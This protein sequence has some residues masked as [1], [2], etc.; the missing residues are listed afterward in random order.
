MQYKECTNKHTHTHTHTHLVRE[1]FHILFPP[2]FW[3]T[4]ATGSLWNLKKIL[5]SFQRLGCQCRANTTVE[6]NKIYHLCHSEW[7]EGL[8]YFDGRIIRLKE[9]LVSL[10]KYEYIHEATII[11]SVCVCVYVCVCVC[12]CA[13]VRVCVLCACVR[14]CVPGLTILTVVNNL[15]RADHTQWCWLNHHEQDYCL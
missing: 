2:N 7:L 14:V 13:C 3:R 4:T 5:F 8:T 9:L 15:L 11:A 1:V 12:V 10:W 6:E